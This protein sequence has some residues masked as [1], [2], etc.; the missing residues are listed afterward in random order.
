MSFSA[1]VRRVITQELQVEVPDAMSFR[2]AARDAE[3][4]ARESQLWEVVDSSD[5]DVTVE[6]SEEKGLAVSA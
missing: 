2:E 1:T 5:Y 4:I 3:R 6:L